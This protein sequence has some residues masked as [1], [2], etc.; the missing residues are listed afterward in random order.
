MI[1]QQAKPD[2]GGQ[3]IPG[4]HTKIFDERK[5]NL[6][7]YQELTTGTTS[8]LTL[9]RYE[10]TMLL[11]GGIPGALGLLLRRIFYKPLF[12]QVGH[13]VIFGRNLTLRH[14]HK[15]SLGSDV[16]IDEGCLLDAK[17]E[18]NTGITIGDGFTLGRFS[19][20]V[21]KNGDI[22]I[23]SH[24]NIGSTVKLVV[25]DNGAIEIGNSLDIGSSCHFSAGSYDYSQID[26]L[27]SSRRDVTRGIKVEDL[28]W[29]G[30]GVIILDG[31][32]IGHRSIVGAGSVVTKDVPPGTVAVGVPAEVIKER[33]SRT[34]R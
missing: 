25:G 16:V 24:V 19:S 5:S 18:H 17:G 11:I 34:Q 12:K 6:R 4:L 15:I 23:G 30:V 9:L 32:T 28:A 26:I 10:L 21:C 20:L 31:I 27:P 8:W 14:P 7:K 1:K 3:Q 33:D 13:N 29:V 2:A 22:K